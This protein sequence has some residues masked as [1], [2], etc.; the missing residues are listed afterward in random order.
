[1]EIK[2]E[3]IL[4]TILFI[5]AGASKASDF[6]LPT[7]CNFFGD[8]LDKEPN[9]DNLIRFIRKLYP[10]KS[11]ADLNLEEIMTYLDVAQDRFGLFGK[12]L[13]GYVIDAN[14]EINKLITSKLSTQRNKASEKHKQ[15]LSILSKKDTVIT[16]NY[17]WIIEQTICSDQS[18]KLGHLV[19][20]IFAF[21]GN[22]ILYDAGM[23]H[24]AYYRLEEGLGYLLKLHGSIDWFYCPNPSCANNQKFFTPADDSRFEDLKDVPCHICGVSLLRVIVPPTMNKQFKKFPRLGFLWSIAYRELREAQHI[25]FWGL[26]L[27][28]SDYYLRWL[29]LSSVKKEGIRISIINTQEDK[30]KLINKYEK[31]LGI[32][33]SY[34]TSVEE[35][36][37]SKK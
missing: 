25:I 4:K 20:S 24:K 19:G 35:Y 1:M 8:N 14:R 9:V 22:P 17:D 23:R 32:I 29:L 37:N 27:A 18:L 7:M 11:F 26:S 33:P 31:L 5:G 21:V 3:Q 13:E 6:N 28:E 2:E 16:L 12:D 34:F 36:L 30:N 10:K 15:L